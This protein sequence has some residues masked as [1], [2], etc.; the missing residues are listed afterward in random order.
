MSVLAPL[1]A[2][3]PFA[4]R[5][6]GGAVVVTVS[7]GIDAPAAGL[8]ERV[9]VDLI[10]GQGNRNVTVRLP[11]DDAREPSTLAALGAAADLAR[12][13]GTRFRVEERASA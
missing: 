8:L 12:R 13:R 6:S 5:R 11:G 9:L 2:V 1:S 10:D 7:G 4:V 3:Q